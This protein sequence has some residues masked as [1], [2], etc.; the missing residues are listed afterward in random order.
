MRA[1]HLLPLLAVAAAV[2]AGAG[3]ARW[4][5]RR[6]ERVTFTRDVAPITLAKCAPC[7]RPGEAGP[8][9]LLTYEDVSRKAAQIRKVT[10]L[11]FMPPWKPAPGSVAFLGDRSLTD[12]Q[13]DVFARWVEQGMPRG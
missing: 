11:R 8:F 4:H 7:H 9:N 2:A 5:A 6:A 3:L 10:G 13:I 1:S 12:A